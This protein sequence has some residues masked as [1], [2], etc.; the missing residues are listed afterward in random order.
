MKEI[1]IRTR[2]L[3]QG[4]RSE[5]AA[6]DQERNQERRDILDECFTEHRLL[7]RITPGT[8]EEV[9]YLALR[10]M[11]VCGPGYEAVD[12]ALEAYYFQKFSD[13]SKQEGQVSASS[14]SDQ[15]TP[16]IF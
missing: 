4:G 10:K 1:L 5:Y 3:F 2:Q 15:E 16:A 11:E 7:G 8:A 13:G 6:A 14:P 9:H 12:A